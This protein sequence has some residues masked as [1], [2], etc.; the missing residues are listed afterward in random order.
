MMNY[1]ILWMLTFLLLEA[2]SNASYIPNN[3]A[4]YTQTLL[5]QP[6]VLI[7]FTEHQRLMH[8]NQLLQNETYRMT[9]QIRSLQGENDSLKRTKNILTE[10]VSELN[11][12]LK[13]VNND[14]VLNVSKQQLLQQQEKA[15]FLQQIAILMDKLNACQQ[16]KEQEKKLKKLW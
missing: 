11:L 14:L 7:P 10:K 5:S 8:Q 1:N 13:K 15:F 2:N 9:V 16:T 4:F 6:H 3:Q 12:L